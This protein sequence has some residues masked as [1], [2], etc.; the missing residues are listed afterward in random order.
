MERV[1]DVFQQKLSD[2]REQIGKLQQLEQDLMASLGYLEGCKSCE[3]P[4]HNTH[5]CGSC[6][7][8]GHSDGDQPILVAG[9]HRG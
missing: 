2:T 4:H 5:E 3:S 1:R 7:H 6:D 9:I 8:N